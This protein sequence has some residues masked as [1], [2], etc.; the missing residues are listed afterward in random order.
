M[1]LHE[2][3]PFTDGR[4]A[5]VIYRLQS[6]DMLHALL[7]KGP[8]GYLLKWWTECVRS[9]R[10]EAQVKDLIDTRFEAILEYTNLRR[11]LRLS[12]KS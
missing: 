9:T 11:L 2:D 5:V 12:R 8:L 6:F 1:M 4:F 3:R 7:V 10:T